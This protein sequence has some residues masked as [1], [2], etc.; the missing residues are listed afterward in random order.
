[1]LVAYIFCL[2]LSG[3]LLAISVFSDFM[4]ADA[5]ELEL[6]S[7]VAIDSGGGAAQIL[8]I[9]GLL[10]SLFGFGAAGA[11]LTSLWAGSSPITTAAV[12]VFAGLASG[13][14]AT[15]VFGYLKRSESGDTSEESVFVGLPGRILV[16][17]SAQG[18]GQVRVERQNGTVDLVAVP[19]GDVEGD[20]AEWRHVIIVEMENG[21]ALVMP[22][23]E[24]LQLG[25]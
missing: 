20:P 6:D 11:A 4:D 18:V 25:P 21:R 1:M 16:P 2:V 22:A 12:A 15:T 8:S 17:I 9:R 24:P 10:Y 13:G 7:D 5:P 19:Y 3:A 23:Q 14:L